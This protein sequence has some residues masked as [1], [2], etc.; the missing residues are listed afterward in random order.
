MTLKNTGRCSV[1]EDCFVEDLKK[2]SSLDRYRV[3]QLVR[4]H[5]WPLLNEEEYELVP[6]IGI[7]GIIKEYAK[8]R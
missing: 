3:V 6:M 1:D 2:C 5:V 8:I 7:L 4:T